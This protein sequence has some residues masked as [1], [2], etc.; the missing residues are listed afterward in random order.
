MVH[1]RSVERWRVC[2]SFEHNSDTCAAVL[3][4][5]ECFVSLLFGCL[6]RRLPV[7]WLKRHR[8]RRPAACAWAS[9]ARASMPKTLGYSVCFFGA[10]DRDVLVCQK[11]GVRLIIH[12]SVPPCGKSRAKF[13]EEEL[14]ECLSRAT[15]LGVESCREELARIAAPDDHP[16]HRALGQD[17]RHCF[18]KMPC[19]HLQCPVSARVELV[20][21]GVLREYARKEGN[22]EALEALVG[23]RVPFWQVLALCGKHTL[24]LR[25]GLYSVDRSHLGASGVSSSFEV[26]D[27]ASPGAQAVLLEVPS[28]ARAV[29]VDASHGRLLSAAECRGIAVEL[30]P[31]EARVDETF[32]LLRRATPSLL[33]SLLQKLIR[34]WGAADPAP[35]DP[36]AGLTRR[37]LL[38][39]AVLLLFQHA[40]SFIPELQTFVRGSVSLLKRAAVIAVEDG[41]PGDDAMRRTG[42]D[43]PKLLLMAVVLRDH[44]QLQP[45]LELARRVTAFFLA[46]LESP[47]RI[48]WQGMARRSGA[49]S[50]A[51]HVAASEWSLAH[52]A[53]CNLGAMQGDK[54]MFRAV[55]DGGGLSFLLGGPPSGQAF[56]L[57]WALDFH[58]VRGV[59]HGFR[60]RGGFAE[61]KARMFSDYT[62]VNPRGSPSS[63]YDLALIAS[64]RPLKAF[65]W[66]RM[67][68]EPRPEAPVVGSVCER[69][70]FESCPVSYLVGD[71]PIRLQGRE[72]I[73][74]LG[75]KD[76]LADEVVIARPARAMRDVLDVDEATRRRAVAVVRQMRFK[77]PSPFPAGTSLYFESGRWVLEVSLEEDLTRVFDADE[78]CA[79][80]LPV[81][82]LE[83]PPA[84]A[85]ADRVFELAAY[86]G[87]GFRRGWWEVVQ[88]SFA[89]LHPDLLDRVL[90]VLSSVQADGLIEMPVFALQQGSATSAKDGDEEVFDALLQLAIQCPSALEA[91]QVPT[92]RARD[93][94]HFLFLRQR[95]KE[96]IFE[97]RAVSRES[98]A[99]WISPQGRA[100]K[101]AQQMGLDRLRS[102]GRRV[103]FLFAPTGAGKTFTAA[104]FALG[105]GVEMV[106]WVVPDEAVHAILEELPKCIGARIVVLDSRSGGRT[107][108]EKSAINIV[109]YDHAKTPA[110]LPK[111]KGWA[112][113]CLLLLDEA[114]KLFGETKRSS[115]MLELAHISAFVLMMSATVLRSSSN[116]EPLFAWA[117]LVS[118]FPT[119][120]KNLFVFYSTLVNFQREAAIRQAFDTAYVAVPIP[121]DY[122]EAVAARRWLEA[123][124]I[125]YRVLD[126]ALVD[127]AL[128][129]GG[130]SFLVGRNEGH[131]ARLLAMLRDAVGSARR[132]SVGTF[133]EAMALSTAR[134]KALEVCVVPLSKHRGYN[135]GRHY[136][137][138]VM[139]PLPSSVATRVQ[140]FGRLTRMDQEFSEVEY[141]TV[142]PKR[143]ILEVLHDRHASDDAVQASIEKLGQRFG[144]LA[145]SMLSAGSG[146]Q[147]AVAG[148]PAPQVEVPLASRA[149][150]RKRPAGSRASA[151]AKAARARAD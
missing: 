127:A 26:V 48:D 141:L 91:E 113:R 49:P 68:R 132:S 32:A 149:A 9:I 1:P 115:S 6:M 20:E 131:A 22:L 24:S 50:A 63:G 128:A 40:G 114:D 124:D 95:V 142:V 106:V 25:R 139:P 138:M 101:P 120:R 119:S 140:L 34:H 2:S 143:T 41:W 27:L 65:C 126:G 118:D 81:T 133:D 28:L 147:A 102:S 58:C 116:L 70:A 100:L 29:R 36:A 47:R 17:C 45:S 64:V 80:P 148:R 117:N 69:L 89:G 88:R 21:L 150:L 77:L 14:L 82:I 18:T 57:L 129:P 67:A 98:V 37:S 151:P 94:L 7:I 104:A 59:L 30:L 16:N 19:A 42:L 33:K 3:A 56:S 39:C 87:S 103:Q 74:T 122:R 146:D 111:L 112:S 76:S 54:D 85:T 99:P 84:C 134:G 83:H 11:L 43:P 145:E 38:V 10:T 86:R 137:R 79:K 72:Y 61:R 51:P 105:L 15:G 8:G 62:G 92:F 4:L 44:K 107:D 55:A 60:G 125:V 144:H 110:L 78:Y 109:R 23:A 123:A 73:V 12:G 121:E 5:F 53:L 93:M 97:R 136:R 13:S 135:F 108:P 66:Q 46:C 35:G 96:W 75:T 90:V 31:E 52:A 130:P 71:V